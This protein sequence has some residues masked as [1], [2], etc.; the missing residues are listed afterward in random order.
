MFHRLLGS[1]D[2]EKGTHCYSTCGGWL[3]RV[4]LQGPAP[5]GNRF[6]LVQMSQGE[7]HA[8]ESESRVANQLLVLGAALGPF[9]PPQYLYSWKKTLLCKTETVCQLYKPPAT[10]QCSLILYNKAINIEKIHIYYRP[11]FCWKKKNKIMTAYPQP[12]LWYPSRWAHW[13]IHG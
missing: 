7:V 10:L 4:A 1:A 9:L 12:T 11:K 2:T 6:N 5:V 8:R 3:C 13:M